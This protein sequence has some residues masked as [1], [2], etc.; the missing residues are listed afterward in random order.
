MLRCWSHTL[1]AIALLGCS[2][3][4]D[5]SAAGGEPAADTAT[6]AADDMVADSSDEADADAPPAPCDRTEQE[7]SFE[8]TDG[9]T[10]VADYLPGEVEGGPAIVLFH[11]IPPAWDRAS[12]PARV[13]A[14]L[15]ESGAAVLNVDR[16]GAGGSGGV[17]VEAY[18]G[19]GGRLDVEA[20]VRFLSA[21]QACPVDASRIGLVGASNGTTAVMDYT[22]G[23]DSTLPGVARIAWLSPGAYTEN[24]NS[25]SD[26]RALLE[27]LP[28]LIVYPDSEPWSDQFADDTPG[29]WTLLRIEG[30]DHGTLNFDDGANEAQQLPA[31]VDWAGG[32]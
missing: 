16:R 27:E 5:A 14:A 2:G 13:R 22:V 7:V 24:Q 25:V 1:L 15:A 17:A 9:V 11:M 18:E 4:N 8:T 10:L 6:D 32:L 3:D 20:A 21:D 12:Y 29:A 19:D 26:N 28:L 31:L 30:G 23:H